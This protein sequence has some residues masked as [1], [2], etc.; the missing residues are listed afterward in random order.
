MRTKLF[1]SA[2]LLT[3]AASSCAGAKVPDENY[4]PG[5]TIAAAEERN[6]ADHPEAQ[7]H[8]KLARD[9]MDNATRLKDDG[10][11]KEANLL[12][13]RAQADADY[14]LALLRRSD[15]QAQTN[16]IRDKIST[17]REEMRTA[18]TEE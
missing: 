2:C 15:Q 4:A 7:L 5:Q 6:A 9:Q 8:L 16:E 18:T 10:K 14:A 3:L 17:L 11:D 1:V 12:M 13:L